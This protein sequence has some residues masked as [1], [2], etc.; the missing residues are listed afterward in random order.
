MK[1]TNEHPT[2][3]RYNERKLSAESYVRDSKLNAVQL[4]EMC[5][6]LSADDVGL[7]NISHPALANQKADILKVFTAFGAC[8]A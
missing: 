4:G 6:E 1:N 5:L 3:K 2:I 8:F 7:V